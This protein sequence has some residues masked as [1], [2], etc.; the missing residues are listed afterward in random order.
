MRFAASPRARFTVP[1]PIVEAPGWTGT[2]DRTAE[3]SLDFRAFLDLLTRP[4][5]DQA[6]KLKA[7]G[8]RKEGEVAWKETRVTAAEMDAFRKELADA[9]ATWTATLEAARRKLLPNS[10]WQSVHAVGQRAFGRAD[11]KTRR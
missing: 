7:A 1:G 6:K 2:K 11:R 9:K 8:E 4:D 5:T 3:L 10:E